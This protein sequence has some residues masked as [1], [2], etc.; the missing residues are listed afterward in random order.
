M[1]EPADAAD[2]SARQPLLALSQRAKAGVCSLLF[3]LK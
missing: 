1:V 2:A 3:G